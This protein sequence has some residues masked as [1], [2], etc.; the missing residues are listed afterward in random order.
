MGAIHFYPNSKLQTMFLPRKATHL[1][2]TAIVVAHIIPSPTISCSAANV[3]R[4]MVNMNKD[5]VGIDSHELEPIFE[6]KRSLRSKVRKALKNMDPNQRSQ[7]DNA[8][9]NSVVESSW[10]KASKNVCAYISSPA[11]LEVDTSRIITEVLSSPAEE[12]KKLYVP[13]VEDRNSNM[14]MLMISSVDDL[15]ENSMNILEPA[16]VDSNGNQREDVMQASDPLDLFILPGLAFDKS[17]SRLGRSGGY[18]DLF[19]KNYQ[20]LTKKKRWKQPLL[21][22]LS[23]SIQIIEEGAIPVTPFDIPVDA[24]VSPAGF[25]P[26]SVAALR[27]CE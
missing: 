27:R 11:L 21:V 20:E 12:R 7:E 23:Y 17:G 1:I 25:I 19:L 26:I 6:Q 24:L 22:A 16:L 13:R 15:I 2:R 10:F 3:S 8:I 14:K 18:Y 4:T 5:C 9:Q